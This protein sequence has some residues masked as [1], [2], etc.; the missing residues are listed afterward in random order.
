MVELSQSFY[1]E[2]AHTLRR[3]LDDAAE[4]AG[5][6]RI[7]GH[8]YQA[9]VVLAGRPD[10]AS[11]MLVDL[12]LVRA[13]VARLRERLDH[14]LLDEVPGLGLPTLENLSAFIFRAL[15]DELPQT[16]EVS[17][18]RERSGDRCRYRP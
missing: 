13:A 1:F 14:H 18:W 6:R 15:K 12:A 5:S 11:G 10:P 7:H 8:T 9:E 2:S 16:V 4:A 3:V 17:V